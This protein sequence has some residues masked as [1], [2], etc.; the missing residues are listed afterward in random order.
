MDQSTPFHDLHDYIALARISG[1]IMAPD[2]ESLLVS[3][4]EPST[5]G[6]E[7]N[8]TLW[9]V[10][11]G[12]SST[13]LPVVGFTHDD[14]NPTFLH[15]GSLLFTSTASRTG[16][17][18]PRSYLR[19]L[20]TEG[21]AEHMA[22][23]PGRLLQPIGAKASSAYVVTTMRKLGADEEADEAWRSNR[24][25]SGVTAIL[26]DGFP[27]R[28]WDHE[29]GPDFARL[30]IGNTDDDNGLRDLAPDAGVALVD[31]KYDISP[32][33]TTV[34]TTWMS[35]EPRGLTRTGLVAIDVTSLRRT[36]LADDTGVHHARPVISPDG[37]LVAVLRHE[38][39]SY[40]RAPSAS[41]VIHDL[42]CGTNNAYNLT[43]ELMPTEY[44]WSPDSNH[45]YVA[46]DRQ[47]RGA[48]VKLDIVTG[49]TH[50]LIDDAVYSHLAVSPDGS[51]IYA[52]RSTID[53][54]PQLV[55]LHTSSDSDKLCFL[56]SPAPP[57]DIPGELIDVQTTAGDGATVRGWLVLPD[58]V[59]S[60]SPVPLQQWIHGG[61][62]TSYNKWSWTRCPWIAAAHGWAV[63]MPDPAMSTGYGQAWLQRAWPH[64][65]AQ[66]WSDVKALLDD[67]VARDEI[68]AERTVC[69]GSSFGGYMANWIAGHTDRFKAIVSHAGIWATDQRG[70]TTDSPS[71]A[72]RTFGSPADHPEWH[73]ENSPHHCVT[74]ITTPMLISHGNLDYRVPYS[75]GLRAFW[76][77]VHHYEGDPETLPHRLL[78][79]PD[80]NHFVTSPGNARA[81]NE[82]VLTFLDWH[83][84]DGPKP[85]QPQ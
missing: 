39:S 68:D 76:D 51:S 78:Q 75:E 12:G 56:P 45:L 84:R 85:R 47:G 81:W 42:T 52:L 7:H 9:S 64:R 50:Q 73:S 3:V 18:S 8:T 44:A 35:R 79:L 5:D 1:M 70:G 14:R 71:W 11:P 58:K 19:R 24:E 43:E 53:C 41:V 63:L 27:I 13:P 31:A 77:L 25:Q 16:G 55:R 30:L 48:V 54:P 29:L 57:P 20:G 40:H 61:P 37:Q 59:S 49:R 33:G 74:S 26:H 23:S 36:T 15:D 69:V 80:E 67:V 2:G 4:Q 32:A 72:Q 10:D 17:P 22:F 65:A 82:A 60:R 34:V 6:A 83:V 66:V 38:Q 62:H 28:S 21:R 46:G